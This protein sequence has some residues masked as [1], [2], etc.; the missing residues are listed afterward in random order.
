MN[1]KQALTDIT[2]FALEDGKVYL[3]PL[4]DCFDGVP[5]NWIIS[6][7][8]NK[9]LTNITLKEAYAFVGN[10]NLLIHSNKDF[11]T[12]SIFGYHHEWIWL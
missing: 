6:K 11:I 8:S 4:L 7:S 3:S 10:T 12:G 9:E 1:H 2:E 5:I